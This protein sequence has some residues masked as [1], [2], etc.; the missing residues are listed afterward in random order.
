MIEIEWPTLSPGGPHNRDVDIVILHIN[1]KQVMVVRD[2]HPHYVLSQLAGILTTVRFRASKIS[3][4]H[5]S[6]S[7][8]T[9][10]RRQVIPAISLSLSLSD[11][12]SSE[13]P[14]QRSQLYLL[15][16]VSRAFVILFCLCLSCDR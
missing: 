3:T 5:P 12:F 1:N 8:R 11:I 2:W 15:V 7:D 9:S 13:F 10:M 16:V 6:P 14:V 4:V